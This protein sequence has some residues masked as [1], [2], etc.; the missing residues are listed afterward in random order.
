MVLVASSVKK[1]LSGK[2]SSGTSHL[3]R[4]VKSCLPND[5]LLHHLIKLVCALLLMVVWHTLSTALQ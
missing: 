5:K 3:I 1:Q 4:H 2:S